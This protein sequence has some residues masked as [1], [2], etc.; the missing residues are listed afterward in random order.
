MKGDY[1]VTITKRDSSKTYSGV[2]TYNFET[3]SLR[4]YFV[5]NPTEI[6]IPLFNV[7]EI[8]ID[9]CSLGKE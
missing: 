2:N 5:D 9:N 8:E 3:N 1:I 7:E 4:L 6:I